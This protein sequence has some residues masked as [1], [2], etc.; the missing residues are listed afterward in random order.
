MLAACDGEASSVATESSTPDSSVTN[1]SSLDNS[2]E[3]EIETGIDLSEYTTVGDLVAFTDIYSAITVG[4][5]NTLHLSYRA[6]TEND[7]ISGHYDSSNPLILSVEEDGTITALEGGDATIY[8]TA[9]DKTMQELCVASI[10]IHVYDELPS[11]RETVTNIAPTEN[12]TLTVTKDGETSLIVYYTE[13]Y[14]YINDIYNS[15]T[16]GYALNADGTM[17]YEYV[18]SGDEITYSDALADQSGIV[19]AKTFYGDGSPYYDVFLSLS[20]LEIGCLPDT[21]EDGVYNILTYSDP[22]SDRDTANRY[23]LASLLDPSKYDMLY[24]RVSA[25]TLNLEVK[26][27]YDLIINMVGKL[28]TDSDYY[29]YVGEINSIGETSIDESILSAVS[30]HETSLPEIDDDFARDI[31]L[32]TESTSFTINDNILCTSNYY[33]VK[34]TDEEIISDY[35]YYTS[36]G[37][38][39]DVTDYWTQCYAEIDGYIVYIWQEVTLDTSG[40]TPTVTRGNYQVY[41]YAYASNTTIQQYCNYPSLWGIFDEP[42]GYITTD[43]FMSYNYGYG[44]INSEIT[45]AAWDGITS[46]PFVN[47]T[48]YSYQITPYLLIIDGLT[49]TTTYVNQGQLAE[50]DADC[51]VCIEL[52]TQTPS[53]VGKS[54]AGSGPYTYFS[55]FNNTSDSELESIISQITIG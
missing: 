35:E 55:N 30:N 34:Y 25:T 23:N 16:Y 41:G 44:T 42:E 1:V 19:T 48:M 14:V 8:Y 18:I 47:V 40:E 12:Y 13:D 43:H 5:T 39:F 54:S 49:N 10:D 7:E 36:G 32:L 50:N 29:T 46:L 38:L 27:T 2:S 6:G 22:D 45:Q 26:G 3:E 51:V 53:Q 37:Y 4:E 11:L 28:R 20:S 24:S 33:A 17:A 21:T 31:S 9:V 15:E 52:Y